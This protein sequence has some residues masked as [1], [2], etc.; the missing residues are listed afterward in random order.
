M[1]M[2]D[3]FVSKNV[4]LLVDNDAERM[5]SMQTILHGGGYAVFS[6]TTAQAALKLCTMIHFDLI[7][8]RVILPLGGMGGVALAQ[9]AEGSKVRMLLTSHARRTLL[10]KIP[11]FVDYD[12][13]PNPF[14]AEQLIGKVRERLQRP[15]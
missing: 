4:I 9:S 6:S 13:L 14:T 15:V 11:G 2:H 7:V 1:S 5:A 10:E 12:F 8:S 3:T